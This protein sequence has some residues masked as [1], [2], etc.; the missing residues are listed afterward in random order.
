MEK[1]KKFSADYA[2]IFLSIL[3]NFNSRELIMWQICRRQNYYIENMRAV[4]EIA[5][6]FSLSL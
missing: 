3:F 2:L 5:F 1:Y 4:M 6:Y